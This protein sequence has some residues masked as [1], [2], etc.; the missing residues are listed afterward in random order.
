MSSAKYEIIT[1]NINYSVDTVGE[2]EKYD[3]KHR[4][5][6]V[7]QFLLSH[8]GAI[9]CLQEATE[10]SIA[11][12]CSVFDAT[13]TH[14]SKKVHPAGR[15]LLTLIPGQ[16]V[17]SHITLPVLE[18]FRDCWDCFMIDWTFITNVHLPMAAKYRLPLS[19][20]ITASVE[21]L[22][23]SCADPHSIILGDWNSFPDEQ[24]YEQVMSIQT[25]THREATSV[26]LDAID[27][28]KRILATF[29]P[30]PYDIIP[31][32]PNRYT[33]HLD[34]IF[35]SNLENTIPIAYESDASDHFAISMTYT[36]K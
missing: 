18:G 24:G 13:H 8:V 21:T 11:D 22:C 12:I 16:Y 32:H 23:R 34:H 4:K 3:W 17:T 30:F 33:Y 20:H 25:G 27:P 10:E 9:F 35:V 31:D 19:S 36:K 29:Q 5:D 28:K 15:Y 26:I 14:H 6:R 1:W 2:F 7:I